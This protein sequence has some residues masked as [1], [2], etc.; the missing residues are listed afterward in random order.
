MDVK[1]KNKSL[2]IIEITEGKICNHCLGRKFSQDIEGPGNELRGQKIRNLMDLTD[3]HLPVEDNCSICG[4]IFQTLNLLA[5]TI[6][7][8]IESLDLEFFSFLVGSIL[9]PELIQ[10]DDEL[11]E[12]LDIEVESIKKELNREL[13]KILES[14]WKKEVDFDSPNLVIMVDLKQKAPKVRIQINPLFL[15]GRYRKLV[16]GIPQ[17]KWPCRKCR[18][19]GCEYCNF[20]GKMYSESVEELIS[21]PVLEMSH[22]RDSKFH[23]AGREDIDVKMLGTGRPFVLE[24]KEP[25][26]R[27]LDLDTLQKDINK[28]AEGKVEVLD[29]KYSFRS[30]K[31]EIKTSSPDTYKIY[32]AFVELEDEISTEQLND[33]QNLQIIQQRTPIRVSHRRADKIRTREVMNIKGKIISPKCLELIIKGQGGLYIKELISGDEERTQ[34]NV[35]QIFGVAARCLT[36]NVLEVGS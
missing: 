16:R 10:K 28:S 11:S 23:G 6:E 30:R 35:S 15:E 33:L 25:R 12:K 8:K 17:T 21:A 26:R 5:D 36:L 19:K 14:R 13:G 34:P 1:I 31:A 24:I 22:S 20:T 32:Q 7:S 18:G 27:N 2:K 3:K 4:C 9:T 29:L